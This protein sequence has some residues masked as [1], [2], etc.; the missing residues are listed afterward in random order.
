MAQRLDSG[1]SG[2]TSVGDTHHQTDQS[3][4]AGSIGPVR[5]GMSKAV[6]AAGLGLVIFVTVWVVTL[7]QWYRSQQPLSSEEVAT[8]L[9]LLPV[10]LTLAAL[11]AWWGA[12]RLRQWLA[13]PVEAAV[14][15]TPAGGVDPAQKNEGGAAVQSMPLGLACIL[16]E[17]LTLPEGDDPQ[18]AWTT[19][20]SGQL[21]PGLDP[22]L[23]DADGMPIFSSRM[24]GLSTQDWLDAHAEVTASPLPESLLRAM[25]LIEAPLH[26]LLSALPS[27]DGLEWTGSGAEPD[28]GSSAPGAGGATFLSGVGQS[29]DRDLALR[30]RE[31]APSLDI[32]LWV[33]A[34]WHGEHR[35]LFLDWLRH[36][37][38]VALDWARAAGS[39][40]PRWSV[41]SIDSPEAG[42]DHL[43]PRLSELYADARPRLLLVLAAQS[44]VDEAC[45]A[46]LQARGELF[47]TH[48][49]G[50]RV[51]GEGAAGLL[52]ANAP[53]VVRCEPAQHPWLGTPCTARRQRSADRSGRP[54]ADELT[55]VMQQALAPW[56]HAAPDVSGQGSWWCLSDADHRPGRA[57][58]LFEAFQALQPDADAM[59]SVLRL[60]DVWGELGV[61]RALLP[62][63]MAA[64]AVRQGAQPADDATEQQAPALVGLTQGSHRRWAIPVWPAGLVPM[65]SATLHPPGEA[66]LSPSSSPAAAAV[67]EPLAA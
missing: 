17:A 4:S 38:G 30:R 5:Q 64:S 50:G 41:A 10:G 15:A 56:V 22:Q 16:A 31:L 14:V 1:R 63:A 62:V 53:M 59:Q 33:P 47:T 7:W 57:S 24:A 60:G 39:V 25:A 32:E 18:A 42:W 48:H 3:G 19:L 52:L 26:Q 55:S 54:G 20:R 11:L 65:A 49:Q 35:S 67:A 37:S 29:G 23:Q 66:T 13:K 27:A 6:K 43:L 58:E 21:R 8:Q 61:A 9:I 36:Q 2:E 51:P 40:E 28:V 46:G 34:D 44:L 12:D 45:V